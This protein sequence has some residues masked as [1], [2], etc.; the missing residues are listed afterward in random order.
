MPTMLEALK[1]AKLVPEVAAK[2]AEA[3]EKERLKAIEEHTKGVV[4][5]RSELDNE[6]I[7]R[8]E[9]Y[10]KQAAREATKAG[11]NAGSREYLKRFVK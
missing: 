3:R 11:A 5:N 7:D 6:A 8:D 10:H 4:E 9:R 1:K 2:K